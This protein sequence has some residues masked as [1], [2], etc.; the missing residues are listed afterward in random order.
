MRKSPRGLLVETAVVPLGV[1]GTKRTSNSVARERKELI[2]DSKPLGTAFLAQYLNHRL[3]E[4]FD[5]T[6]IQ[7]HRPIIARILGFRVP[8]LGE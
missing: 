4:Y 1:L 7:T 8:P 6:A 5:L 3:V 2:G